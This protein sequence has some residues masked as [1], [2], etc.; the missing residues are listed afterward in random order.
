MAVEGGVM[1][2]ETFRLQA[3]RCRRL[4]KSIYNTKVAADLETYAHE[5]ELRAAALE[6]SLHGSFGDLAES[7]IG[8]R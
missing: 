6:I 7:R 8:V 1:Q 3:E 5:L 4:A 2:S